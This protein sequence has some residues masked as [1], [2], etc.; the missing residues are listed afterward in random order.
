MSEI[1]SQPSSARTSNAMNQSV[2]TQRKDMLNTPIVR[3]SKSHQVT[4]RDVVKK[5][6]LQE[7]HIVERFSNLE[8]EPEQ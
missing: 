4:Y 3:G 1:L 6:P 8:I 7:V 2:T 5:G